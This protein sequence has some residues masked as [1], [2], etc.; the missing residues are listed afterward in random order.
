MPT[1]ARPRE[2]RGTP[3]MTRAARRPGCGW[4]RPPGLW[5]RGRRRARSAAGCAVSARTAPASGAFLPKMITPAASPRRR[6][7]WMYSGAAGAVE[8][9]HEQLADLLLQRQP[10]RSGLGSGASLTRRGPARA[11]GP[12][13]SVAA[14][15][16]ARSHHDPRS[17]PQPRQ[18]RTGPRG[19]GAPPGRMRAAPAERSVAVGERPELLR[20]EQGRELSSIDRDQCALLQAHL[21]ARGV[22]HRHGEVGIVA[23]EQDVLAVV[24]REISRR[25]KGPPSRRLSSTTSTP[26]RSHASRAVS[27]ALTFGLETQASMFSPRRSSAA[28]AALRLPLALGGEPALGVRRTL[29]GLPVS[30]QPDHSPLA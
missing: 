28:P 5:T 2:W 11:L 20:T 17:P 1:R 3:A 12:L 6:M 26:R 30:Q 8:A 29:L 9:H 25:S 21:R 27:R 4:R 22:M 10:R 23:N 18:R 13:R 7:R 16:A 19:V 15:F 14:L 24:A